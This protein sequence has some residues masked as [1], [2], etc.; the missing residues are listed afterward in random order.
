ME[1]RLV[2]EHQFKDI[3]ATWHGVGRSLFTL[4]KISRFKT[5]IRISVVSIDNTV[6][7]IYEQHFKSYR[8][9]LLWYG[10]MLD[11]MGI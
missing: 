3:L 4:P 2:D 11:K 9:V 7:Y 10:Q 5:G 1:E 6:Q 8:E